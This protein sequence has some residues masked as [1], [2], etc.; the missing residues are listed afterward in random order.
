[1]FPFITSTSSPVKGCSHFCQYCWFVSLA[2]GRLKRYYQNGIAPRV[3]QGELDRRFKKGDFVFISDMG[4]LFCNAVPADWIV[5][6]CD[7]IRES[8][9]AEF[10]FMTKNPQRYVGIASAIPS[11]VVLG[12]TIESD[13]DYPTLSK[14]PSQL[15]RLT[16]MMQLIDILPNR[17]FV[18]IEPILDFNLDPFV[19][20]LKNI[21]PWAVAIG[22]DNYRWKLP[23]PSRERANALVSGLGAFTTVYKKT[24]RK[25]WW[26]P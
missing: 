2:T 23:E 26:E 16:A 11:N 8:P 22:Y 21:K 15:D 12:A 20:Q 19:E 17:R 10:L 14:A 24:I 18:S 25:A 5:K 6:V 13:R 7:A 4:D 9:E 3:V 1:M